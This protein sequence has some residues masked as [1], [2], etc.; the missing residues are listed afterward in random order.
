M[1]FF[2][3]MSLGLYLGNP[4]GTASMDPR[5]R[6]LGFLLFTIP[7]V[8][9]TPMMEPGDI[10]LVSTFAYWGDLVQRGDM[11][12]LIPPHDPRPFVKRVV[13]IAGDQ[14]SI[15]G[16]VVMLNGRALDEPYVSPGNNTIPVNMGEMTIPA[17][18]LFV[19]GDNRNRSSDSRNF[20]FVERSGVLGR[21][22]LVL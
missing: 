2:V 13:A 8:S 12:V 11:L 20:G 15:V 3:V 5:A 21:V 4:S 14:L 7:T 18:K 1:L 17:D 16:G 9:N 6:L 19:M 22:G 10:V